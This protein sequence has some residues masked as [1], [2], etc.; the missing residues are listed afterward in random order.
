M[1]TVDKKRI[2]TLLAYKGAPK[3]NVENDFRVA[4][5]LVAAIYNLDFSNQS[6]LGICSHLMGNVGYKGDASKLKK[7]DFIQCLDD[8]VAAGALTQLGSNRVYFATRELNEF[9]SKV[10]AYEDKA[11]SEAFG[12]KYYSY[13]VSDASGKSY[14]LNSDFLL[15]PNDEVVAT[16]SASSEI[17]FVKSVSKVRQ[18]VLGR[19]MNLG[20]GKKYALIPDEPNL[21]SFKFSFAK[22]SDIGE[23]KSGDVVIAK[24]EKRTSKEIFVS[25]REVVKD[26]GN[27]N[28]IIV[29]AVLRNDIPNAWPENLLR[30]LNRVPD[31]VTE[32]DT[33]GRTD[34]RD[35]P[36]VTIDGEDARDFDDAVY[37]KKEKKGWKLYVSIA[38]VSYYVK[39]NTL[40]DKEAMNR[41]NSCYFPNFV[42]PMLPEKL[43]NGICSLNPDV[44]RLC[45]TC[46]M[47]I[48]NKGQIE[49][50]RFYPAVMRSHARLTYNEAW[51]MI[52]E[53]TARF[54]EHNAVIEDVKELYNL[55]QAL[56][57][58]RIHRGGISIETEEKTFIFDEN[59]EITGI[60]PLVRNDAHKLIEECM[61][62]ANVAA[63]SYVDSKKAHTLY[64]VHA[65][66]MEKKLSLLVTQLA[67]FGYSLPGGRDPVPK[68]FMKLADAISK[69][70]NATFLN[71]LILRSMSKAEYTPDN[72]G[73][74]G[75]ALDKY[76]HF[77]SP[78]RRYADLQLH[79]VIKHL[80]EKE[81][82]FAWGKIGARSYTKAEL[83]ALGA[84]CTERE[85]AADIAER[86]VDAT[87][88][89]IYMEQFVGE[90]V[91][92]TV[93]AC[94]SFGVFV[95]LDDYGVD[96]MIYIGNFDSYMEYDPMSN[97]LSSETGLSFG[98]GK[99]VEVIINGIN[100]QEHKIDLLPVNKKNRKL[101]DGL[102]KERD[103]NL[104]KRRKISENSP[105]TD[106]VQVLKNLSD[107]SSAKAAEDSD[108]I[109]R[110][111]EKSSF[112]GQEYIQNPYEPAIGMSQIKS[113]K[114]R[115]K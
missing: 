4:L 57:Q 88:A 36:L 46:E 56:K 68:D 84:K 17:A 103:R 114:R 18:C 59:M 100:Q 112:I 80:L 9:T 29:M 34:L 52:E 61:I 54:E 40:L 109:L 58:D 98:V 41:C 11:M 55:Y 20:S 101:I 8:L 22:P 95:H 63:A 82:D 2:N 28:N 27:L 25:V 111:K 23:A 65:R 76:A 85:I 89:C 47:D 74:F 78:I 105:K 7:Q 35:L 30:T 107:I 66:P 3:G 5:Y 64:R 37:C 39:P 60:K 1:N 45:M 19:L 81:G 73:H 71:E 15:L 99:K 70:E 10:S 24:I 50:Y 43:S 32:A 72:I 106:K 26:I 62:A 77:T 42:I 44:D 93:T 49:H 53:G 87:L 90:I 102:K 108:V 115:R 6:K 79:R 38:D 14:S 83:A 104:E 110:V 75:L 94:E 96:G 97:T 33:R 92:G 91:K 48:S 16:A 86:E 12:E 69:R 51:Q 21:Q 13:T 31:E 113:R 67:R